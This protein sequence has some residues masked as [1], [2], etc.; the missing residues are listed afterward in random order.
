MDAEFTLLTG[1]REQGFDWDPPAAREEAE[2]RRLEV[3]T[4]PSRR[5]RYMVPK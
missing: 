3:K 4:D 1:A 5:I 2:R